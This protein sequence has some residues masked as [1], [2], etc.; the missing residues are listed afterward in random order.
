MKI[1]LDDSHDNNE[2]LKKLLSSRGITITEKAEIVLV[3]R[4]SPLPKKGIAVVYDPENPEELIDFID[5]FKTVTT[6]ADREIIIGKR[7][8]G[9]SIVQ[10]EDILYFVAL[11][12][13]VYGKTLQDRYEIKQK[14]YEIE[15]NFKNQ[16][17]IR[18]NKSSIINL[19]WVQE[20]IPWFG[21]RLLLKVKEI[22]EELEVSRSYVKEFKKT[23]GI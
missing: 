1:S 2:V 21:G 5:A 14:L 15:S 4:G 19:R 12:N 23:L 13:Y 9:Y 10:V 20:I 8:Y 17:F 16:Y 18:I 7:K 6:K 3:S 11:G 22:Q